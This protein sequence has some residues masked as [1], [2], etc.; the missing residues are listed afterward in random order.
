MGK[1]NDGGVGQ[2]SLVYQ[3]LSFPNERNLGDQV[4]N[5]RSNIV[6]GLSNME[7]HSHQKPGQHSR[8]QTAA[9]MLSGE[10]N[11]MPGAQSTGGNKMRKSQVVTN[12]DMTQ[13]IGNAQISPYLR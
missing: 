2:R 5:A 3:S 1:L 9:I 4:S 8:N 12:Q 7:I 10:S 6:N 11:G 13:I